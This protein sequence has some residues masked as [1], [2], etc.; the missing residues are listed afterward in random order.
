MV[1]IAFIK[2]DEETVT[3]ELAA[4]TFI[5]AGSVS[6][7]PACTLMPGKRAVSNPS[8]LKVTVYAPSGRS[9]RA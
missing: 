6:V 9:G 1:S 3:V 4:P 8:W 7:R 5:C 2:G